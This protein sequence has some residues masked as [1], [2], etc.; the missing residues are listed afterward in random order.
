M[1]HLLVDNLDNN[2]AL[3]DCICELSD[4]YKCRI[5]LRIKT[6]GCI[7]KSKLIEF[8]SLEHAFM[9]RMIRFPVVD[10][11]DTGCANTISAE[12]AIIFV[13][14]FSS[15]G[16]FASWDLI[17][18]YCNIQEITPHYKDHHNVGLIARQICSNKQGGKK[19][20]RE[21]VENARRIWIVEGDRA[22]KSISVCLKL[23][24][25]NY[26]SYRAQIRRL[27]DNKIQNN[28]HINNVLYH[29]RNQEIIFSSRN[30]KIFTPTRQKLDPF[31]NQVILQKQQT[32]QWRC[33]LSIILAIYMG[34]HPSLGRDSYFRYLHPDIISSIFRF[35]DSHIHFQ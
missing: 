30:S 5:P 16:I 7:F 20:R 24:K 17:S 32:M 13:Q 4:L 25:P 22:A 21:I 3:S 26:T 19:I 8:A 2:T 12:D 31:Y 29:H 9:Y 10:I 23:G 35:L 33:D 11:P 1:S 28:I 18:K 6:P 14:Q 34:L 15:D 27:F